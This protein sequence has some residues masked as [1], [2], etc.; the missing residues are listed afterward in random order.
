[1]PLDNQIDSGVPKKPIRSM[2]FNS[3]DPANEIDSNDAWTLIQQY[4][5]QHGLVSQ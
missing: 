3:N 1:M 2:G 5:F 4:F